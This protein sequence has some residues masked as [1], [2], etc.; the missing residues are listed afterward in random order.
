MKLLLDLNLS[1]R[2][3]EFLHISGFA[4]VHWSTL[5]AANAPDSLIM[6]YAKQNDFIVVTHDLDFGAIHAATQGQKPSVIQ[7]RADDISPETI[8]DRVIIALHQMAADL[9]AGAL[10]TIDLKRTRIR[11]LPLRLES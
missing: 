3:I 8:A 5:G 7:L 4:A 6:E 2:W 1:V 9:E 10:V 11:I